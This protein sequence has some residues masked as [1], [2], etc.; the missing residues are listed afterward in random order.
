MRQREAEEAL[1]ESQQRF[2]RLAANA[3]DLIFR[4]EVAPTA[5][6]EYLSP[7][8]TRF[9]GY[10]PEEIYADADL[11]LSQIHPDDRQRL[12]DRLRE[13]GSNA[14]ELP[15]STP[16]RGLVWTESVSVPVFAEAGHL[17]ALEGIARDITERKRAEE[18]LA[19]LAAIVASSNDAIVA[20][21][22]SATIVTW[23]PAAE[24]IYGYTAEEAIGAPL[25]MIFPGEL[26]EERI[27]NGETIESLETQR[28]T[29]SG[30][31][32]DVELTIF[33]VR[34]ASGEVVGA[35][36]FHRDI[37]ERKHEERE[38]ASLEAQLRHAQKM[39]AVGRL[40]GG[41]AHDFNNLLM[42][43]MGSTEL[44]LGQLAQDDPL[45]PS[46]DEIRQ[47]GERAA[48]LTRQLLAFS[49]QQRLHKSPVDLNEVVSG[50][51]EML[52]RLIGEDIEL[53]TRL[54]PQVGNVW[55]DAG[56]IEQVLMNL[57]VNA[58]DAITTANIDVDR[59]Y[60]Q[61][62]GATMP[63]GSYVLL[64]VSDTGVGM[65]EETRAQVF[66][67]FFT[68]KPVG[69]GTGLGLA[70]VYGI[71]KQSEGYVWVES[72]RGIGTQLLVYL[73]RTDAE[74]AA[75]ARSGG[76]NNT[77]RGQET[78]LLVED[79]DAVRTL[80]QRVLEAAG[81]HVLTAADG[82]EA[83]ELAEQAAELDLVLTDMVLPGMDGIEI[84]R[85]LRS[86]QPSVR[87]LF[88]SGYSDRLSSLQADWGKNVAFLEKP[89]DSETLRT[90]V[91]DVLD[92]DR[93]RDL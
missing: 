26:G 75:R 54:E 90:S 25:A 58:R 40:A 68:T 3:P 7:A 36:A 8:A 56:Q 30:E 50:I 42:V 81:Y 12:E 85:R 79:E 44:I 34:D 9:F 19:R 10:S 86:L 72:A 80:V 57:A 49:R 63:P 61:P 27:R 67:P 69:K 59:T 32:V 4:I 60:V 64:A 89:F 62:D 31:L 78:I 2:Q 84:A 41:I 6:F 38:R 82:L 47:A 22:P 87:T 66:E 21:D 70:T 92:E 33:P 65:D 13:P 53:T 35:A 48:S 74:A 39:E 51:E 24:R 1:R 55:A 28:K 83:L 5:R 88:M 45:R 20:N 16:H 77:R 43:L 46:V 73:P 18:E 17:V 93:R 37:T 52:R 29:K 11:V 91:R 23:N 71:V 15:W 76:G 14:I